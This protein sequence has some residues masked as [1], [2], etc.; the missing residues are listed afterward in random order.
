MAKKSYG[1]GMKAASVLIAVA[2]LAFVAFQVFDAVGFGRV[3]QYGDQY[4]PTWGT[5]ETITLTY[6]PESQPIVTFWNLTGGAVPE[7]N[8]T[9]ATTNLTWN[10]A[11]QIRIYH[12]NWTGTAPA[13][14]HDGPP[15]APYGYDTEYLYFNYTCRGKDA[16][17]VAM[18]A[19]ILVAVIAIVLVAVVMIHSLNKG[20][21]GNGK[22]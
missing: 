12:W 5:N 18:P 1:T 20:K 6:S 14:G 11:N 3:I 7:V 13:A 15:S 10:G 9:V 19:I 22:W 4:A 17:A 8:G 21:G 16:R 2:C